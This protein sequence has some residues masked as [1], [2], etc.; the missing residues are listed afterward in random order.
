ML[1]AS[2]HED[3]RTM[4]YMLF[5][6]VFFQGENGFIDRAASSSILPPGLSCDLRT[7]AVSSHRVVEFVLHCENGLLVSTDPRE[8]DSRMR[9]VYS[10]GPT[11]YRLQPKQFH[12]LMLRSG[13]FHHMLKI[14]CV[15]FGYSVLLPRI[16]KQT[17]SSLL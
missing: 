13:N 12:L 2:K 6:P 5:Y 3:V 10:L 7:S 11:Y 1:S 17:F 9:S 14:D 16:H 4:V 15:C 8:N